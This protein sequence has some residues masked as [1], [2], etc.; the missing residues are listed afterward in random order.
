MGRN[1]LTLSEPVLVSL[2]E[3]A[4][5]LG[6]GGG[7][8]MSAMLS[9]CDLMWVSSCFLLLKVVLHRVHLYRVHLYTI[10]QKWATW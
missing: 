6:R 9:S 8:S 10:S 3:L 7:Q 5:L 2:C 1:K 4:T